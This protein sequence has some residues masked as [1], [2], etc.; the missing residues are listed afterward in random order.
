MA[1]FGTLIVGGGTAG[2]VVAARL[3]EDPTHNV[4]LIEAGPD[5]GPAGSG[6]WPDEVANATYVGEETEFDWGYPTEMPGGTRAYLRGKVIGGSS[7]TNAA[8]VN[9][10]L[11]R[12]YDEWQALGN[13]GWNFEGLLPYFQKVERL[14]NDDTGDPER[15][16][17]GALTVSRMV[18]ESPFFADYRLACDAAGL[19]SIDVSGP[20]GVTGYGSATRNSRDGKRFTSAAAYLDPARDRPNLTILADTMVERLNWSGKNVQSIS[21][22]GPDGGSRALSAGRIVLCAGAVG[23]PM[24]MQHSGI[25][26]AILL[27]RILGNESQIR[28]MPGVGRNLHDHCGVRLSYAAADGARERIEAAG[29]LRPGSMITRLRGDPALDAFNLDQFT[30]QTLSPEGELLFGFSLF[31]IHPVAEGRLVITSADPNADPHIDVGFGDEQDVEALS[32]GVEWVRELTT[33][34]Q[35]RPW[36]E[37]ERSPGVAVSGPE[38]RRWAR[39]NLNSYHHTTGTCKMGPAA[40]QSAVVDATGKVHGFDNLYVADASVMP[41]IP[42]GMIILSVYAIAEK[43]AAGL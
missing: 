24:I 42:R 2:C 43:I 28:D 27:R 30:S 38:L 15:G 14:E 34:P 3:T 20:N 12:D 6:R 17:S 16:R 40:D 9:W 36:L 10:G 4:A 7:A 13:P 1:D 8:G 33:T 35:L 5:F 29:P 31:L 11:R 25:G 37:E 18:P 39:N 32:R 41:T 19:K 21:V 26:P 22:S 23:D